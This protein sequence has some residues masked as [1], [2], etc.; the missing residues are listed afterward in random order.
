VSTYPNSPAIAQRFGLP[1]RP[2]LV[3]VQVDSNGPAARAGVHANDVITTMNGRTVQDESTFYQVLAQTPP[4]GTMALTIV[5]GSQT[6]TVAVPLG[7]A[8]QSGG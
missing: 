2:G 5:R 1:S 6:F 8:P 7:A 4:N 3:V